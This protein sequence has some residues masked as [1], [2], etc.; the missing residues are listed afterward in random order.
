MNLK[1]VFVLGFVLSGLTMAQA[2]SLGTAFTYQGQL[3]DAGAPANGY[4]DFKF[5]LYDAVRNGGQIGPTLATNAVRVSDG[6]FMIALDFGAGVFTGVDRWLEITVRTNGSG[7][8]T[9]L[10]PRQPLS[11]VPTALYALGAGVTVRATTA[12]MA[13]AIAANGVANASLQPNVVTSDKIVDGTIVSADISAT[14]ID[15]GKI[16]GGD[17]TVRRLKVGVN[18]TL[19]GD[20]ATIAGGQNNTASGM[21]ATIGGGWSHSAVG[22]QATIGGGQG[23]SAVSAVTVVC[24]GYGNMALA[25]GAFV[26]GGGYDGQSYNGNV[27]SGYGSVV[28]G[29]VGNR[30]TVTGAFVGGGSGNR[31]EFLH[32][33]VGGGAG[34][35]ALSRMSTVAGGEGNAATNDNA[36]VAGGQYNTASGYA[37]FVGGG[38]FNR[39][40]GNGAVVGGGGWD[41]QTLG[42]NLASGGA[43]TVAGGLTNTASAPGAT[44]GGGFQN[45]ASAD[46]A[47]VAGGLENKADGAEAT[48]GGGQWNQANGPYATV[49]GGFWNTVG[50][51]SATVGGGEQNWA[52]GTWATIPGGT[53]NDADGLCSFAAGRGAKALHAG[54]FVWADSANADFSS[55]RDNQFNIRATGGLRMDT[56]MAPAISLNAADRALLACGW[57][58]FASGKHAG[59]GRWGLFMEPHT[60]ALGMPTLGGKTVQVVRYNEDSTSTSLAT[61]D[62]SG[63]LTIAGVLAE[64]S[65][66]NAKENFTPVDSREVLEKVA[67]LPISKWNFKEDATT[68][69]LGPMAQDFHA[70]FGLGSDDKHIAAVDANGVALA[71]IQGLNRKLEQAVLAKE[72]QITELTTAVAELKAMV[73]HLNE[74]LVRGGARMTGRNPTDPSMHWD[75]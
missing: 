74:K 54:A 59:L 4:Y 36:T 73:H 60:L 1:S 2:A 30:A 62:Q 52:S 10:R 34:N 57:D 58:P 22:A 41:G 8:F 35:R 24:G 53:E 19:T 67:V 7:L 5:A 70:A 11:P 38:W 66:R 42:G 26:G 37:A 6:L 25:P 51:G 55:T 33:T 28:V 17:L 47:T 39:A 50:G 68:P 23:N 40:T 63:N 21:F 56:G 3:T 75:P 16:I 48:V 72:A 61:F 12:D 46:H 32:A 65:D 13:S 49:S 14:G 27:A 45:K 64:H 18:H 69:H 71:A 15:G 31:A 43:S 20:L 29:G 44:V 9:I